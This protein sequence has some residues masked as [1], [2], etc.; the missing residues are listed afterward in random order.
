MDRFR[1]VM[2]A[3]KYD[4]AW[5]KSFRIE[6]GMALA[7]LYNRWLV[8]RTSPTLIWD[9]RRLWVYAV[10]ANPLKQRHTT[11]SYAHMP[12]FLPCPILRYL[13]L[14]PSHRTH[15]PLPCRAHIRMPLDLALM[16]PNRRL[17]DRTGCAILLV[18]GR[19]VIWWQRRGSRTDDG[20]QSRVDGRLVRFFVGDLARHDGAG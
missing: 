7:A 13:S 4:R 3:C 14:L 15:R 5:F 9:R 20:A 19:R 6:L 8:T 11:A 17:G 12:E 18:V 10:P 2:I 16:M 1:I